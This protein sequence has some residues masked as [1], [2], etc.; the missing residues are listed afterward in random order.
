MSDSSLSRY[1]IANPVAAIDRRSPP[2]PFTAMT[3]RGSPVRGSGRSN[4][5]L[6]LPPPKFVMRRSAPRR[7]ER[8]CNRSSGLLLRTSAL[9]SSHRFCSKLVA[10]SR[11]GI[12]H[13]IPKTRVVCIPS[14]RRPRLKSLQSAR[15]VDHLAS[16]G[17]RWRGSG[18]EHLHRDVAERGGLRGSGD[19]SAAGGVRCELVQQAI[20]RSAADYANFF[21]PDSGQSFE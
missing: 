4:F 12:S 3:R 11:A 20:L 16:R 10:V 19:H 5:E 15:P 1:R 21:E 18:R 7:F 9:P 2:L 13:I 6:V 14:A 17:E 8:Y